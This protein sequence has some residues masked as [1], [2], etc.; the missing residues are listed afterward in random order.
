MM[1]FPSGVWVGFSRCTFSLSNCPCLP[2]H[3]LIILNEA[4]ERK[5]CSLLF[6]VKCKIRIWVSSVSVLLCGKN[7]LPGIWAAGQLPC[8]LDIVL[9]RAFDIICQ[10]VRAHEGP[11]VQGFWNRGLLW[12]F[13]FVFFLWPCLQ[14]LS[15][16]ARDWTWTLGSESTES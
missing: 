12:T 9:L 6:F 3:S 4:L 8:L 16:P 10:G 2:C 1:F 15:P 5:E 14:D 11:W 7:W 13:C